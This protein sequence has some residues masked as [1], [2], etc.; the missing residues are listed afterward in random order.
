MDDGSANSGNTLYEQGYY[1][2]APLT[3]LPPAGTTVTAVTAP[4]HH[5]TLAPDYTGSNVALIDTANASANLT[6]AL[7]ARFAR[8][9]FLTSAGHGPVTNRCIVQHLD[10]SSETNHFVSPDWFDSA[11]AA[12]SVHGRVKLS[13]KLVDSLDGNGPSLFAADL[14]L[15]NTRSPVTN[16]VV[17]YAGGGLNSHAVIF[18]ASGTDVSAPPLVAA[19]LWVG[20]SPDAGWMIYATAPGRLQS[21]TALDG[22]RT[23]WKDEGQITTAVRIN[24]AQSER[25]RFYR[26]V[27]P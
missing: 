27:S 1:P 23:V 21:T 2:P 12:L 9:S 26:V 6:P 16:L 3:G 15:V 22:D 20:G 14:S 5:Y 25:T 19:K 11:P 24:P 4:D 10:G 17:S 18:A 13:Q 7:P 8:L